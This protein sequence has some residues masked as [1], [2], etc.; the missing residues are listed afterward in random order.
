MFLL[1]TLI[2]KKIFGG[3]EIFLL[4]IPTAII[5]NFSGARDYFF[6]QMRKKYAYK[7]VTHFTNDQNRRFIALELRKDLT[8]RKDHE[9]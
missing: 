9:Y 4:F 5:P 7:I 6:Q 2:E 8:R 1:L 3:K